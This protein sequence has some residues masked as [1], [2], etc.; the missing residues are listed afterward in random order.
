MFNLRWDDICPGKGWVSQKLGKGHW[1]FLYHNVFCTLL[2]HLVLK[3]VEGVFFWAHVMSFLCTL[4]RN[5][6][7]QK[8]YYRVYKEFSIRFQ[9]FLFFFWWNFQLS[10]QNHYSIFP[11][12]SVNYFYDQVFLKLSLLLKTMFLSRMVINVAS[13]IWKTLVLLSLDQ[14]HNWYFETNYLYLVFLSQNCQL[15]KGARN[16]HV[17]YNH[18]TKTITFWEYQTIASNYEKKCPKSAVQHA[19]I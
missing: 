10:L 12:F 4:T 2:Y 3:S 1:R 16:Y 9:G 5:K 18:G 8:E 13:Q 19:F 7:E 15:L 11:H 17:V 6:R 14:I